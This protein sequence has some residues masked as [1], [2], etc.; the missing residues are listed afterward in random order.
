MGMHNFP[1]MT[2]VFKSESISSDGE[3]KG[4][5]IRLF[6]QREL[7]EQDKKAIYLAGS[8]LLATIDRE[9]KKVDPKYVAHKAEWL[10]KAKECFKNAGLTP[11]FIEETENLY[12]GSGNA[13]HDPWLIVTT[14]FGRIRFGWRKRVIEIDWSNSLLTTTAEELFPKEGVT[15]GERLIH[16]WGYEKAVEYLK[17]LQAEWD[18]EA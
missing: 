16:A 13:P 12:W 11:I 10:T 4:L 17:A 7:T 15:K 14:K 9:T 3:M 1:V 6:I 5:E 8:T 18:S 2:T